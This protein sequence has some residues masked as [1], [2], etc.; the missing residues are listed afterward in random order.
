MY[1]YSVLHCHRSLD[2]NTYAH[3]INCSAFSFG[4]DERMR[5]LIY[6]NKRVKKGRTLYWDY[7]KAYWDHS[8]TVVE[9]FLPFSQ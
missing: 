2:P 7:G 6:T 8:S 5:L 9:D 4:L 1:N 3:R